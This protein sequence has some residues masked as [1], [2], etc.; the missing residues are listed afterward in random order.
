MILAVLLDT[1]KVNGKFSSTPSFSRSSYEFCGSQYRGSN[2]IKQLLSMSILLDLETEWNRMKLMATDGLD[3]HLHGHR[4][5][6]QKPQNYG[7]WQELVRKKH[8]ETIW[9]I[10]DSLGLGGGILRVQNPLLRKLLWNLVTIWIWYCYDCFENT[11]TEIRHISHSHSNWNSAH[12]H[13][14]IYTILYIYIRWRDLMKFR[15]WRKR[16]RTQ[17]QANSAS[18][19]RHHQQ[20]DT[21][22]MDWIWINDGLDLSKMLHDA[23]ISAFSCQLFCNCYCKDCILYLSWNWHPSNWILSNYSISIYI[24]SIYYQFDKNGGCMDRLKNITYHPAPACSSLDSSIDTCPLDDPD[25]IS[26]QIFEAH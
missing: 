26:D 13:T 21:N 11:R 22:R 24:I 7:H 9:M 10:L 19:G 25:R 1:K 8:Q 6:S 14:H 4:D 12:T 23:A 17:L 2:L 18:H 16:L 20:H 5:P 15:T 3:C